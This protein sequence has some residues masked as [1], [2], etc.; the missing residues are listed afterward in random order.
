[1]SLTAK[2]SLITAELVP[3][4]A[5]G[6][7]ILCDYTKASRAFGTGD[8]SIANDEIDLSASFLPAAVAGM[9][10]YF[11]GL[12]STAVFS[13]DRIYWIQALSG[14]AAKIT[15]RPGGSAI[16]ITETFSGNIVDVAPVET[17]GGIVSK[18]ETVAEAERI[19]IADY[20]T[21]NS[22]NRPVI[23]PPASVTY[24]TTASSQPTDSEG[25]AVTTAMG[26]GY[27]TTLA[28]DLSTGSDVT[29]N[30]VVPIKGGS[31]TPGDTSGAMSP[32][33]DATGNGIEQLA[34]G[35]SSYQLPVSLEYAF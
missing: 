8:V 7:L 3:S 4:T 32:L 12:S 30:Y 27:D 15:D 31:A 34:S 33:L 17:V 23:T 25:N 26:V 21:I 13:N 11:T 28:V 6:F 5:Y 19:E 2:A 1:M 10:V 9:R 22:G 29:F 24:F 18:C 20:G 35:P 14:T 16:D